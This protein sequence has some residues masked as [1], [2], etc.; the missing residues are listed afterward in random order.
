[1]TNDGA[2]AHGPMTTDN[3]ATDTDDSFGWR[4]VFVHKLSVAVPVPM[5]ACC[6][7]TL[8]AS[9]DSAGHPVLNDPSA[10]TPLSHYLPIPF[11]FPYSGHDSSGGVVQKSKVACYVLYNS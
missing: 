2:S 6:I 9:G 7:E 8:L 5:L 4:N 11:P 1:M 3:D 10:L